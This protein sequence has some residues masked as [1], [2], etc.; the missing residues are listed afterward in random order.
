MK[1]KKHFS[2]NIAPSFWRRVCAS[3]ID[4]LVILVWMATIGLASLAV[5][6][7]LG[8]YPNF[9]GMLGPVGA[10]TVFFFVLTFPVG[11]YLFFTESGPRRASFGKRKMS[12]QVTD[13]NGG[14][15]TKTS[16][17]VRTIIK[18][19]PWEI[20]HTFIWQM[21]YIFYQNGYNAEVPLW[22]FVGLNV[23]TVLVILY[24]LMI[25]VRRDARG[26]HDIFAGTYVV[27][28]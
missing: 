14:A 7:L 15:L 4:Y 10:Q 3:L 21:Q 5:Y 6:L 12:M 1:I 28:R 11:L 2:R 18:L 16:I 20:A 8:E 13:V 26:P 22:I 27:D 24:L 23:S 17:L 9:L 25:A 19:L